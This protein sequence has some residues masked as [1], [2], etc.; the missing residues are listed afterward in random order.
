MHLRDRHP[1]VCRAQLVGAFCE[2]VVSSATLQVISLLTLS[3]FQDIQHLSALQASIRILPSLLVG[4]ILNLSTG[5]FVDRIPAFWIVTVTSI[6]SAGAPLL[7]AVIN[8]S[9]PYWANAFVAQ[10]L[11]PISCDALFTVGLVLITEVFPEDTQ[12]LAG[13]VFNTA[14]QFGN[15]F[16]LAVVQIVSALVTKSRVKAGDPNALMEGYR[17]SFWTMFAIMMVCFCWGVVGMRK[18][19]RIGLKQD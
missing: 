5:V 15:A 3:S 17:A 1:I 6:L 8:P 9:W 18:I 19:G 12:G 13:G 16:G 10:L 4:A 2:F 14:S 11:Q 7:M